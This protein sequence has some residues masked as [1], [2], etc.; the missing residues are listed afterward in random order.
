MSSAAVPR[1][2]AAGACQS[3]NVQSGAHPLAKTKKETQMNL[4][5][6]LASLPIVGL[7]SPDVAAASGPFDGTWKT[8]ACQWE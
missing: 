5:I 1:G 7:L 6:A 8:G 3:V 4:Q 2:K